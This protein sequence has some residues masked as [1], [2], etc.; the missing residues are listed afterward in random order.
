MFHL[1]G[2]SHVLMEDDNLWD[3]D[4]L[5]FHWEVHE[6]TEPF[7]APCK[8]QPIPDPARGQMQN[9]FGYRGML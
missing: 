4:C 6:E 9:K 3:R 5:T 7:S 8:S 1:A 2:A